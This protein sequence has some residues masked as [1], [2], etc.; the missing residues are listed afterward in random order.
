LKVP[1]EKYGKNKFGEKPQS[2]CVSKF[3]SKYT[4]KRFR[5]D[6]TKAGRK[7]PGEG[8]SVFWAEE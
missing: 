3:K 2:R 4:V 7:M 6:T 5:A 1:D 8:D